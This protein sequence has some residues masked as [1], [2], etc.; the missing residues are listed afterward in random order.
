MTHFSTIRPRNDR[1]RHPRLF[2][3][4]EKCALDVVGPSGVRSGNC[5]RQG[6]VLHWSDENYVLVFNGA[7]VDRGP[8]NDAVLKMVVRLVTEAPPSRVQITL[9]NHEA[10]ALT[11]DQFEYIHWYSGQVNTADRRAFFE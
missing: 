4:G 6:W 11:P 9:G 10:V 1:Q 5:P 3:V 8:K 7:L 2:R